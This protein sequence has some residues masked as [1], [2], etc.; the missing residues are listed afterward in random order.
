MGINKSKITENVIMGM[1][2]QFSMSRDEF[3]VNMINPIFAI[4]PEIESLEILIILPLTPKI[5]YNGTHFK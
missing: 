2:C 3:G 4:V 5:G 1:I